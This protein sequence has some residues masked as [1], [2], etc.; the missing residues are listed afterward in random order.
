VEIK[1]PQF[2]TIGS[3]VSIRPYVWIY[4]ITDDWELKGVFVPSIEIG[5]YCS[6]GRFCHITGSNQ[7]ILEDDVLIGEGV[8]IHD[9]NHGY[10]DIT[11]PIIKQPL[12]SRGPIVIGKGTWIGNG[13]KVVGKVS[14]GRNC[15]VGANA[16]V[17]GD[18]P[19]YCM[20]VGAP[21]RIVK[22]FDP[23]SGQW[24]AVNESLTLHHACSPTET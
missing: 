3:G 15:V 21:A 24:L 12:V 10:E 8:L 19:D 22:R 6:I 7:V 1:N 2:I 13:A 18:V 23:E 4:A 14:I 17:N 16:F 5:N 9:S 11:T 20:V